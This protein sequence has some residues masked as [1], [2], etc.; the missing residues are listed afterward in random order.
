MIK[1]GTKLYKNPNKKPLLSGALAGS[2]N[3]GLR[4][5]D[6]DQHRDRITRFASL[7]HRAKKQENICGRLHLAIRLMNLS[8]LLN[9][10]RNYLNAE[11]TC[12]LKITLLWAK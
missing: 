7:K 10:L 1:V 4:S 11:T 3:K 5:A 12:F 6:A 9:L 2:D 8:S